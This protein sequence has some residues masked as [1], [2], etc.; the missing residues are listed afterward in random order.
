MGIGIG[1]RPAIGVT[2]TE[3]YNTNAWF[4]GATPQLT[5]AVWV[6]DPAANT[7]MQNIPEFVAEEYG[8]SVQGGH[9]PAVIWKTL[10]DT[11]LA[12]TPPTD[13]ASPP[14]P[15]R[16]PARVVLPGVECRAGD[17]T[18]PNPQPIE[19]QQPV[20]SVD[21]ETEIVPCD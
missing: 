12:R 16:P 9:F 8:R 21:L 17:S 11:A 1:G 6:G 5:T 20:T 19:P 14:E 15:T 13:W 7:P 10:T 2:G 18:G 4:V 3:P